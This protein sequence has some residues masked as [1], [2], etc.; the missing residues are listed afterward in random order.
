MKCSMLIRFMVQVFGGCR[1]HFLWKRCQ[2]NLH[3]HFCCIFVIWTVSF[4]SPRSVFR[5]R[6][7]WS[8]LANMASIEYKIRQQWFL[9]NSTASRHLKTTTLPKCRRSL[10]GHNFQNFD[11]LGA[12][13]FSKFFSPS[14]PSFSWILPAAWPLTA[15]PE[16]ER[17]CTTQP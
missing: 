2:N 5:N 1:C 8:D 12:Q 11:F 7:L 13:I 14:L 6:C 10:G 16:A 17:R 9:T 3:Q 15:A 4:P